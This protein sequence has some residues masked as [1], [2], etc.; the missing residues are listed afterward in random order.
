MAQR[1]WFCKRIGKPDSRSLHVGRRTHPLGS[2]PS[3][4]FNRG[5]TPR[6]GDQAAATV[7]RKPLHVVMDSTSTP[8][9]ATPARTRYADA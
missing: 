2:L 7:E 1:I 4:A 8:M 3:P 9:D 6:P 5:L